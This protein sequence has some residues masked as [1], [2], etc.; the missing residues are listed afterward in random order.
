MLFLENKTEFKRMCELKSSIHNHD[1]KSSVTARHYN[2]YYSLSEL[3]YK[4]NETD[5]IPQRGG[6]KDKFLFQREA[7]WIYRLELSL[8]K[9]LG[10]CV[11]FVCHDLLSHTYETR[12][13]KMLGLP[14]LVD[15]CAD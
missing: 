3:Y 15:T 11:P 1:D 5:K 9:S 7:I 10:Y 4:G 14:R 13:L 8:R 12:C 2:K 6:N